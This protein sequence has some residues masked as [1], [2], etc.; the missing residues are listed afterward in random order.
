MAVTAIVTVNSSYSVSTVS[1]L[2]RYIISYF[3]VNC[4]NY[5]CVSNHY[6]HLGPIIIVDN[7]YYI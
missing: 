6:N 1:A 2:Y 5:F 3:L 4:N 7:L